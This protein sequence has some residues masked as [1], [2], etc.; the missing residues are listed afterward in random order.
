MS[1]VDV[2][3]LADAVAARLTDMDW[4]AQA[5]R[6]QTPVP[7]TALLSVKEAAQL[8]GCSINALRKKVQRAQLPRGAVVY[9]GKVSYRIRRDKLLP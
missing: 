8:L 9:T 1:S 6:R 3:A 7:P 4:Q 5:A 2:D